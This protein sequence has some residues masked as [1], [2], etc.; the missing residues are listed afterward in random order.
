MAD[1]N[2]PKTG[3]GQ[4]RRPSLEERVAA[5]R[6]RARGG[7][8]PP[9]PRNAGSGAEAARRSERTPVGPSDEEAAAASAIK[10]AGQAVAR[11]SAGGT[12][13]GGRAAGVDRVGTD[14]GQPRLADPGPP[15]PPPEGIGGLPA[16]VPKPQGLTDLARSFLP[17]LGDAVDALKSNSLPEFKPPR[18]RLLPAM[19]FVCVLMLGVR[20]GEFVTEGSDGSMVLRL[21]PG[22][23][24]QAQT[25]DGTATAPTATPAPSEAP[26]QVAQ[27]EPEP[28]VPADALEGV[29]VE[30]SEDQRAALDPTRLSPQELESLEQLA[31]RREQLDQRERA[32]DQRA[33]LLEVAQREVEEKIL[34]L[35]TLRDEIAD[36][37]EAVDEQRNERLS[38]LV[39][40]YETMRPADAATIFDELELDVLIGVLQ[41]MKQAKSAPIIAAMNP[42]RARE[43]TIEMVNRGAPDAAGA[44]AR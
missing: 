24:V 36:L 21:G 42:N 40:I 17:K 26:V 35:E 5:T 8:S 41:R 34:E 2:E 13:S 14:Q 16:V 22:D 37:L 18:L 20:V 25:A 11:A 27:A 7:E 19:I 3:D 33:S 15:P 44:A 4:G 29:G 39:G 6:Q 23:T 30:I 28:T 9:T 31:S 1:P 32:L 38:A 12:P 10:P 43:V